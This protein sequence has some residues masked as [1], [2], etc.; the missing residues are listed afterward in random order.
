MKQLYKR[1]VSIFLSLIML[2]SMAACTNDAEEK[3]NGAAPLGGTESIETEEVFIREE[4]Y[5]F[6][7]GCTV[8]GVVRIGDTLLVQGYDNNRD[9][10]VFTLAKLSFDE[11]D[12]AKIDGYS[13]LTIEGRGDAA[14]AMIYGITAGGDGCFYILAGEAPREYTR[15]GERRRN[16]D[17][18]GRIAVLRYSVEGEFLGK[19]EYEKWLAEDVY[20]ILADGGGNIVI[21]GQAYIAEFSF[22]RP[23]EIALQRIDDGCVIMTGALYRDDIIFTIWGADGSYFEYDTESGTLSPTAIHDTEGLREASIDGASKCQG[24]DG[25]LILNE[26][27]QFWVCEELSDCRSKFRWNYTVTGEFLPY[28][29]RISENVFVCSSSGKESL[30]VIGMVKQPMVTQS[31]VNVA[32]VNM[33]GNSA[34]TALAEQNLKGGKY[35][36]EITEYD[37]SNTERLLADMNAG[38]SPDLIIFERGFSTG[39]DM[40]EDLY[41][42]ID[43]DDDI[44][45]DSFIP[46]FLTS[47]SVNGELLEIWQSVSINTVAARN[48]D[49][50]G[51][52]PLTISDYQDIVDGSEKY[53]SIFGSFMTKEN[54]LGWVSI[55]GTSMFIDRENAACSFDSEAFTR[56]LALCAQMR[57]DSSVQAAP[58][59]S[60]SLLA[61]YVISSPQALP[62]IRNV[63]GED[64]SF[65]GFPA[66]GEGCSYYSCGL[67]GRMAIPKASKNKDGAWSFIKSMLGQ[68]AQTNTGYCL[69]VD[70][71]A[72]LRQAEASLNE[73][74]VG[75]LMSLVSETRYAENTADTPLRDIIRSSGRA[76]LAGE[77]TLEETT[78]LIQSRANIY[79]AEKYG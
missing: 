57:T 74:D 75:L 3:V 77:K 19:C 15:G 1:P 78:A 26:A 40:F 66:G 35:R 36:Y 11:F 31:T 70:L 32:L 47:L 51:E 52:T 10:P 42:Y 12:K 6:G 49:I 2:L 45:R 60:E 41:F 29:C 8:S 68:E 28:V 22:D 73:E 7:G 65:V 25:E 39:A 59:I 54:L 72:L 50:V 20:G 33:S 67:S 43:N 5:P 62:S 46:N 23:D 17:Y 18:Q 13:T 21:Y 63:L 58:D 53:K 56:L 55:V 27:L 76:F 14:R 64:Y 24:L 69:P 48:S 44:S 16:P 79:M 38:E 61:V 9:E 4:V 34:M 71:T 30:S 37:E